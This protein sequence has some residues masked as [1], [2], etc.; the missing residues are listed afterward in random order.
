[1]AEG[2]VTETREDGAQVWYKNDLIHRDDGPA[3]IHPDGHQEWYQNGNFHRSRGPAVKYTYGRNLWYKHGKLHRT[4]GPAIVD[5]RMG[6]VWF[7][8]DVKCNSAEK[9]QK[10]ANISDEKLAKLIAKYGKI[11]R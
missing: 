8:N 2:I 1:M 11:G 3:I 6:H 4:D 7:V 5:Y 10:A 9:F